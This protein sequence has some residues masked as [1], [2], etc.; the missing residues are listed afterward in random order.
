MPPRRDQISNNLSSN[1]TNLNN[2]TN[3]KSNSSPSNIKQIPQSNLDSTR[4]A[5]QNLDQTESIVEINLK[6]TNQSNTSNYISGLNTNR[7]PVLNN[8]DSTSIQTS[9][10]STTN[11][12]DFKTTK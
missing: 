6:L 10:N 2:K 4:S 1:S 12:S 3:S 7:R 5:N 9:S 11:L 8:S